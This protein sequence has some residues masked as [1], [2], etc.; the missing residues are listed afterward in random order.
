MKKKYIIRTQQKLINY[1]QDTSLRMKKNTILSF[2]NN[3]KLGSN[4]LFEGK[5]KLGQN[6]KIDSN[7]YLKEVRIGDNNHIKLSSSVNN[8]K[9]SDN[10]IIG[11]FAFIR[12]KTTIEKNCI[13]GAYVEIVRSAIQQNTYASHRA[14]IGD[15]KIARNV[16]IG[17]GTVFCNYN[18]TKN[19][20]EKTIIGKNCKIGSNSTIIAPCNVKPNTIIP[21][22][23][24]YK[25]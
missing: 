9:I 23:T 17:A 14:F 21:A 18:F 1:F 7:C 25:K 6:N 3:L 5:I 24:K 15:A 16:I 22:L 13:V 10:T 4:I 11:P 19:S 8:C 20:K 12:E 2:H